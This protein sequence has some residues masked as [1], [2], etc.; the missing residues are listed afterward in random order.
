MGVTENIREVEMQVM[1]GLS[2]CMSVIMLSRTSLANFPIE[3]QDENIVDRQIRAPFNGMRGKRY[4]SSNEDFNRWFSGKR[5]P[6][7]GM[8]GKRMFEDGP[9]YNSEDEQL[10]FWSQLMAARQAKRGL[11][12]AGAGFVGMRG[13]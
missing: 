1:T 8:R 10:D 4:P 3:E 5:A 6:F 9:D 13:R 2:V 7:N 11:R 12:G